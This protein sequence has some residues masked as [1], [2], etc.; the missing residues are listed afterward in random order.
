MVGVDLA[1]LEGFRFACRPGCGLCCYG[2]PAVSP[3]ERGRLLAIAPELPFAP[4]EDGFALLGARPNGGA[5]A[6][7]TDERCRAHSARPF[8]CQVYPVLVHIGAR[9]QATAVLACPGVRA[10][11]WPEDPARLRFGLRPDRFTAEL[12]AVQ[13]EVGTVPLR[14]W[15][16]EGGRAEAHRWRVSDPGEAADR[17]E[18]MR[19]RLRADPARPS[20]G[21]PL[22]PPGD[23][24][25]LEELPV[26]FDEPNGRVV[27]RSDRDGRYELWAVDERGRPPSRLGRY[28]PPVAPV[29]LTSDG[30]RVLSGYLRLLLE[31]DHFLWATYHELTGRPPDS[32]EGQM[33]ENL[34][35]AAFEVERRA[36]VRGALAGA[37]ADALDAEA[38]IGGIRALDGELLDRPTAG[39]IL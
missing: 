23:E 35:D 33:R 10:D 18:G 8:P 32:I 39:R 14:A 24:A 25:P 27:S 20:E 30:E 6:L 11:D 13:S 7:L 3:E 15:C 31:R 21:A 2:S 29:E 4:A 17:V 19:G 1:L 22:P 9:A 5:C 28:A 34:A 37:P 36:V 16:D 26:F 12:T 38:V